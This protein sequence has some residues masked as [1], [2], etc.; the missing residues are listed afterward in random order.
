[1]KKMIS[2]FILIFINFNVFALSIPVNQGMVNY[3]IQQQFPKTIK[4]IELSNP[5]IVFI[6]NKSILCMDGIPKIMFLD[7]KFKFCATF[8]PVWNEKL[9]RLEATN[10]ELN[11]MDIDGVGSLSSATKI[12]LN[13]VLISLEP[14]VLYKS[15]SWLI[16]QISSIEVEKGTMYLKF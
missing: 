2:F 3:Q 14:L 8:K 12:I 13:E 10:L 5:Q 11:S 1:M 16:K 9:S 15:D 7:K 6:D 4:K